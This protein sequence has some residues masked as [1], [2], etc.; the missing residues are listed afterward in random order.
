MAQIQDILNLSD[1]YLEKLSETELKELLAPLIPIVRTPNKT[2]QAKEIHHMV[3][4]L[5]KLLGV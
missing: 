3:E 2:E 4:K 1:D 5:G